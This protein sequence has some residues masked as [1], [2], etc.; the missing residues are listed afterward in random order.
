[1]LAA[2]RSYAEEHLVS[3][4]IEVQVTPRGAVRRL[5]PELEI[6][7]FRIVQEAI[8][9]IANHAAAQHAS[10]LIE[11]R[12]SEVEVVVEDDGRGF[13]PASVFDAGDSERGFG[14]LGMKERATLA[15][16]TLDIDSQPGRG[17]RITITMPTLKDEG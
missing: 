9:N 2:M 17:T 14:L 16:G 8:N 1:L 6:T 13:D 4:G 11:F 5:P 7:L 15:E 10:V 3:R 12:D